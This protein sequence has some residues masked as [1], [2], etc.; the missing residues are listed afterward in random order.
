MVQKA[1][2]NKEEFLKSVGMA[3]SCH[4]MTETTTVF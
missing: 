4:C 1:K 3:D 2:K